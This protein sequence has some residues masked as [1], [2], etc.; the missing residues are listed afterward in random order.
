MGAVVE[1][2]RR[3]PGFRRSWHP[4]VSFGGI[5][6]RIDEVLAEHAVPSGFGEQS[7]LGKLYAAD[8][9]ILL[10]GVGHA[11]SSALHLAE[12]RALWPAKHWI[13]QGAAMTVDGRATWVTWRELDHDASDFA[14]IGAAIEDAGIETVA[15]IGAATARLVSLPRRRRP[16]RRVDRDAPRGGARGLLHAPPR[17]AGAPRQPAGS[18]AT[19]VVSGER[20][21]GASFGPPRLSLV[22]GPVEVTGG[23]E[24]AGSHAA[25]HDGHAI[26]TAMVS[27]P[28]SAPGGDRSG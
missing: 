14:E 26:S 10:L 21:A 19:A 24:I 28:P 12:H 3:Y 7:P 22:C 5:G 27:R 11:N 16:R 15:S 6:P 20:R 1:C 13:D 8:A 2:M 23:H 17:H 9:S 18:L 25:S 4:R